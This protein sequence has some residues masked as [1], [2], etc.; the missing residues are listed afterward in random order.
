MR[1]VVDARREDFFEVVG[2]LE[3]FVFGGGHEGIVS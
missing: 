1:Y 2:G 3:G